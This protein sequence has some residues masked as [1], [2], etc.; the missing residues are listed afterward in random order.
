MN[1]TALA[2]AARFTTGSAMC[3]GFCTRVIY[4]SDVHDQ[5]AILHTIINIM[6]KEQRER[7]ERE[8]KQTS[9]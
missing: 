5:W 7:G 9:R 2:A 8:L 1:T 3:R 6:T 4:A